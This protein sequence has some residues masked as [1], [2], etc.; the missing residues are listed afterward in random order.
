MRIELSDTSFAL[1]VGRCWWRIVLTPSIVGV[2]IVKSL[3]IL[4]G[5]FVDGVDT[6]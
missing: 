3:S 1:F 5:D 2:Q 4:A 6:N